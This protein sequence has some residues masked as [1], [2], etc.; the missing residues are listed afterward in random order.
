MIK[1]SIALI[2][3]IG[4]FF[5]HVLSAND[6]SIENIAPNSMPPGQKTLVEVTI[7][8]NQIQG[9]AKMEIVLPEG[10]IATP[11]ETK[12]ASFTFSDKKVRFVWMTLPTEETF[13]VT[14]YLECDANFSGKYEAK[15]IF[16]YINDNQRV[17]YTIPTQQIFVSQDATASTPASEVPAAET[18]AE[19]VADTNQETENTQAE[20]PSAAA[21]TASTNLSTDFVCERSITRISDTEFR[22]DLK[23]LNSNIAGFAKIV[24]VAPET[25]KTEKIQDAGATVTADKNAI[26]FVWFE[27]PVSPVIQVSYKL[28]SLSPMSSLPVISGKLS[29]VENNNPKEVAIVPA[30]GTI[31]SQPAVAQVTEPKTTAETP[32]NASNNTKS[33]V[34]PVVKEEVKVEEVKPKTEDTAANNTTPKTENKTVRNNE[35]AVTSVP[36]ADTGVNYKVQILAAHRV[37]NKT[38]FKQVHGYAGDFNIE[39]HEG[40]VKYTTGKYNE[41]KQARDERE[42]LKQN[43]SSLPGPFV[44][45]YN[46]GERITVQEALLITK[47]QWYQ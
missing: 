33:E 11:N 35:K 5:L 31:S 2:N 44:T 1:F 4:L 37:V 34:K 23:I 28:T 26:K 16:S 47:E 8:K 15:G 22:V 38:Y 19:P 29:F 13:K 3:F 40:W 7:N 21:E 46:N 39:N 45:A 24:D 42:R 36:S 18:T 30:T 9:F 14:Y 12:G 32:S 27:M 25:L 10:F 41:Y 20:S 17:D 6:I 43:Y